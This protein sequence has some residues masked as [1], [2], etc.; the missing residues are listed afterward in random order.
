MALLAQVDGYRNQPAVSLSKICSMERAS[1][2]NQLADSAIFVFLLCNTAVWLLYD[3]KAGRKLVTLL[4]LLYFYVLWTPGNNEADT[5]DNIR[6]VNGRDHDTVH[7][8][9]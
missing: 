5:C 6:D 2:F 3:L 7:T 1:I 8:L 9:I 4:H